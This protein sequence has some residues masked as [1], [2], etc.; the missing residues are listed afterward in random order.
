M[1]RCMILTIAATL[2]TAMVASPAFSYNE[3]HV[4][5][6]L[7]SKHL[8]IGG[9][10][11]GSPLAGA[12]LRNR[13]CR[14]CDFTGAD[15]SGADLRGAKF[16]TG[17]FVD[18]NLEGA[19]LRGAVFNDAFGPTLFY[20]SNL[21]DARLDGADI[22]GADFGPG[23]YKSNAYNR[24][25]LEGAT[26]ENATG[27]RRRGLVPWPAVPAKW[28]ADPG[29]DK[30]FL[31]STLFVGKSM[32][33]LRPVTAPVWWFVEAF[34]KK[35]ELSWKRLDDGQWI[36]MATRP[37]KNGKGNST[38]KVLFVRHSD[39]VILGQMTANGKSIPQSRLIAWVEKTAKKLDSQHP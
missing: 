23:R 35:S 15:L 13:Q 19:D 36:L 22:L 26:I 32:K 20:G 18:A 4:K 6:I 16:S 39:G 25:S 28:I 11:T 9:D 30:A 27:A 34:D 7:G 5:T 21:T 37:N 24:A 8:L 2:T 31:E 33:T 10:L 29:P 14:H 1:Y 3:Q 38:N 17:I 12:D